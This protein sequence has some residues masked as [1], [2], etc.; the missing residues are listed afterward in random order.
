MLFNN[1]IIIIAIIYFAYYSINIITDLISKPSSSS[2]EESHI[3]FDV[4]DGV[5]PK[6]ATLNDLNEDLG[7]PAGGQKQEFENQREEDEA[8]KNLGIDLRL[9]TSPQQIDAGTERL[10]KIAPHH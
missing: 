1:F 9:E 2:D 3:E 4:G 8:F 5:S 7:E 10:R 6:K